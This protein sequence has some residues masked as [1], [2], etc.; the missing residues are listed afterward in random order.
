MCYISWKF[1]VLYKLDIWELTNDNSCYQEIN[2]LTVYN[3]LLLRCG[4]QNLPKIS[5]GLYNTQP[6]WDYIIYSTPQQL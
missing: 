3:L 4:A 6:L 5:H 1:S 2:D